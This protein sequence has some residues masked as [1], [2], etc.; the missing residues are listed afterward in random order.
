MFNQKFRA[1]LER[2][3]VSRYR[4]AQ[5][6]RV[7]QSTV[8]HWANGDSEPTARYIGP[9]ADLLGVTCDELC[10]GGNENDD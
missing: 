8:A 5:V 6:L 9:L 3:G 10:M 4:V 7:H 2:S 1:A